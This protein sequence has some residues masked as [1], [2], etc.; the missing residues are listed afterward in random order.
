MKPSVTHTVIDK[1]LAG[2][3]CVHSKAIINNHN[4]GYLGMVVQVCVQ[5][6]LGI[7]T[8]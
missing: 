5:A 7:T 8:S 6:H 3:N 4:S 1:E 2:T